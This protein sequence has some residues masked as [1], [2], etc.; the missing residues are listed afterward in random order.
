MGEEDQAGP[1]GRV[2]EFPPGDQGPGN[3]ADQVFGSTPPPHPPGDLDIDM[4]DELLAAQL[5]LHREWAAA[6]KAA[7]AAASEDLD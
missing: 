5:G 3:E 4:G 2:S 1:G 6:N 7:K